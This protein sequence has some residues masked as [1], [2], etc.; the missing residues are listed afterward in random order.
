M[1][2]TKLEIIHVPR[3]HLMYGLLTGQALGQRI[4]KTTRQRKDCDG[5]L[6]LII[7]EAKHF[8]K[9]CGV[10]IQKTIERFE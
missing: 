10:P 2:E 4:F 3:L 1:T 5:N 6:S 8:A 7:D 9:C